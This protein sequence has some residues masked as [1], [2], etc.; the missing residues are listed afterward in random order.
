MS[1]VG[2]LLTQLDLSVACSVPCCHTVLGPTVTSQ[3]K[4]PV[5]LPVYLLSLVNFLMFVNLYTYLFLFSQDMT[6]LD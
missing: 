4:G 2:F 6:H 5:N 1:L 3:D